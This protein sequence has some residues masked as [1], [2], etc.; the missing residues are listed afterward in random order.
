M[1]GGM[2]EQQARIT[3]AA[4]MAQLAVEEFGIDSEFIIEETKANNTIQNALYVRDILKTRLVQSVTIVT[5]AFHMTR[6][7]KIFQFILGPS[8]GPLGEVKYFETSDAMMEPANLANHHKIEK[9]MIEQL[10]TH[11][12]GIQPLWV[13]N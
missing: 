8:P 13:Q 12:K 6:A 10:T 5:S 2:V 1:T 7:Q 4:R 11:L 9:F 3:E